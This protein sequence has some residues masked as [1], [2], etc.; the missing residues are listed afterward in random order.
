MVIGDDID[1]NMNS[2]DTDRTHRCESW[3]DIMFRLRTK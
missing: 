2:T 3:R 1:K